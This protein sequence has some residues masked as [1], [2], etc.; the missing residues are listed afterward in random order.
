MSFDVKCYELAKAFFEG[1]PEEDLNEMAQLVQNTIELHSCSYDP[2]KYCS[3]LSLDNSK[4]CTYK[5]SGEI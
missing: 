1:S 2:D 4:P 3:C 5:P